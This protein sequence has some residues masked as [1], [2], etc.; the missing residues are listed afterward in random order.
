MSVTSANG[1]GKIAAAID[2]VANARATVGS[3]QNRLMQTRSGLLSYEDNLR[4]AESKVRDIDMAR[5]STEFSKFQILGQVSN[6][7][8][9]QANTAPEVA[10]M[11]LR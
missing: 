1:I 6:A 3:Q 7:M 10:L 4:S 9:A 11:L 8:L 5:E 2:H